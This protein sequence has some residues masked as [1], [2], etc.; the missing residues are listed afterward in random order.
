MRAISFASG[1]KFPS[2]G[3]VTAGY[4]VGNNKTEELMKKIETHL[5]PCD[6]EATA[7][8]YKVLA[9]QI[10]TMN[11]RILSAYQNTRKFVNY[12]HE[13]LPQAKINF[14]SEELANQGFTPS[15]FSLDLPTKGET[16]ERSEERRVGKECRSRWSPEHYK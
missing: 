3:K 14:V 8:Q 7:Y 1:S 5:L 9:E 11:E 12:I 16:E 13:V 4:C 6:N 10:P 15:V 2:G